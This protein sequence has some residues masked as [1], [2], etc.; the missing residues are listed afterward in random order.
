VAPTAETSNSCVAG[1][2]LL[3][4]SDLNWLLHRAAQRFGDVLDGVASEHGVSIRGQLVLAALLAE[5]AR[6]QLALGVSLGLDKTTLTTTLDRL[7]QDGL[8]VRRPHP[9]DRR[10]RIPEITPRGHDVQR[11][12]SEAMAT[13]ERELL[14]TLSDDQQATL[15]EALSQLVHAEIAGFAEHGG[16]CI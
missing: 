6:T 12:V 1:R 8:V 15:R 10:V 16:S 11:Q 3:P 5:P 13:V 4:A 2:S 9:T 7:E 14:R